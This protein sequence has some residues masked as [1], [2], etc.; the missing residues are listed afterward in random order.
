MWIYGKHAVKAALRNPKRSILRLIVLESSRDFFDKCATIKPEIVDRHLFGAIFGK[1]AI[2]QGCAVQVKKL[3]DYSIEELTSDESD[4]RPFVF[5]DQVSDPQNIGS[6]LR[7]SAVFGARAVVVT[8]NNSP[9][10]TPAISKAASGAME[11]IPLIRVINLVHT[12]NNLKKKGFWCIGLDE[13]SDEKIYEMSL[14]GKFILVVGSEGE[15]LRRLTRE[16]CDFL[17]QLPCMGEF[18]TLNAAQ[19]ATVSLYEMLRQKRSR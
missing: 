17:I 6:I 19:A 1:D 3:Q 8:E 14:N 9:E 12:I 16:S 10:L 18:S 7:A 11:S 2:H 5:L 15:G 13:R 4:D